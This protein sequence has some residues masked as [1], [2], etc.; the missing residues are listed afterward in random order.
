[1]VLSYPHIHSQYDRV[2]VPTPL[3]SAYVDS[4]HFRG[5]ISSTNASFFLHVAPVEQ[6]PE[7]PSIEL[8]QRST[9]QAELAKALTATDARAET[10]KV[11]QAFIE[12]SSFI[13]NF[14]S[15]ELVKTLKLLGV[16]LDEA[17]FGNDLPAASVLQFTQ[18]VFGVPAAEVIVKPEFKALLKD[19]K[20][21]I[22][23]VKFDQVS[24]YS[25]L[26]SQA[27]RD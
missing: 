4:V 5:K 2:I 17:S 9:F 12:G 25:Y 10:L 14:G 13:K 22:V 19:L 3:D 27:Y 21:V 16:L 6:D 26:F 15:D 7:A 18:R 11:A 23:A 20:D 24:F 1:L 8:A